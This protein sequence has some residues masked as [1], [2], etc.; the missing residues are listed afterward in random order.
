MKNIVTLMFLLFCLTSCADNSEQKALLTGKWQ[1]TE[2]LIGQKNSGQ[3]ASKVS[4]QFNA[5]DTYSATFGNQKNT[6]TYRISGMKLY[7]KEEG[8][9]EIVVNM[10]QLTADSLSFDM[11]RGGQ[12]ET[13]R[14]V[15]N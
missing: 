13:L 11:N 1:G 14:F 2:W 7:T 3:D 9:A 6:G 12:A 15:R 4:F 10:T 8:K 5:D